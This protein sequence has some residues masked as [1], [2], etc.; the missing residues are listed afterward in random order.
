MTTLER[1]TL[2]AL[3]LTSLARAVLAGGDD[4][5]PDLNVGDRARPAHIKLE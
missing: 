5:K 1:S 4:K 3:L 2:L